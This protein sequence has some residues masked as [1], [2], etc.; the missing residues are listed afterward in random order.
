MAASEPEKGAHLPV[1]VLP[2]IHRI[3]VPLPETPLKAVNAYVISDRKRPLVIDTGLD[4]SASLAAFRSAT[5]AL[6]IDLDRT[7][8]LITH[9]HA[10]HFGM[11]S[12]V[13]DGG[14]RIFAHAR[15]LALLRSFR[16]FEPM[17]RYSLGHGFPESPLR[18]FFRRHPAAR[19]DSGW[20]KR[21]EAVAEG[22]RIEAGAYR[23]VCIET[24]GHSPGH[25]CLYE[26]ERK[27]LVSGDHILEDISS[28]INCRSDDT[29]PLADYLDSLEK[30]RA[31]AVDWV[32]PGHRRVFRH[33]RRRIDELIEH[34]RS[35]CR[36]VAEAMAAGPATAYE[37]ASRIRWD[38]GAASWGE[39]PPAQR[40]FALGETI[41]HLRY[42]EMA[43]RVLRRPGQD[44]G[45]TV[46]QERQPRQQARPRRRV[47]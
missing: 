8:F 41:A 17:I 15:D 1:E 10:D 46:W 23:F 29:N 43:G 16:S 35:R 2:G 34:H 24:P 18:E 42:L 22:D 28:N 26:P 5:A 6:G 19:F 4:C 9:M 3:E 7:D 44:G 20:A 30:V 33:H 45:V 32:L 47:S 36:E 39:I 37:V 40:W 21:A 11:V 31:L 14:S 12:K 27:I 13:A 38:V 25:I